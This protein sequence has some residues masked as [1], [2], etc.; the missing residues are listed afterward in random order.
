MPKWLNWVESCFLIVFHYSLDW[1]KRNEPEIF[2][3][4]NF[5]LLA[6]NYFALA[7]DNNFVRCLVFNLGNVFGQSDTFLR[8]VARRIFRLNNLSA[9]ELAPSFRLLVCEYIN[10]NSYCSYFPKFLIF[11][12]NCQEDAEIHAWHFDFVLK[13]FFYLAHNFMCVFNHKEILA[14][15]TIHPLSCSFSFT[16]KHFGL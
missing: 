2:E 9:T 4:N 1:F 13:I 6:I 14:L 7:D 15:S 12:Q 8:A 16:W 10:F 5:K 11:S 3:V